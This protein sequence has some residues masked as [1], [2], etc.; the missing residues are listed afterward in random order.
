MPPRRWKTEDRMERAKQAPSKKA[1]HWFGRGLEIIHNEADEEV[2]PRVGGNLPG[3]FFGRVRHGGNSRLALA[4]AR[5]SPRRSARMRRNA[6]RAW[7]DSQLLHGGG[8]VAT[9][10]TARFQQARSPRPFRFDRCPVAA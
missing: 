8:L 2:Q 9:P 3:P 5:R 4:G 6:I 7:P 1:L 10:P